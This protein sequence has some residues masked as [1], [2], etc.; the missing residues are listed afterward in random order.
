MS[1]LREIVSPIKADR[2]LMAVLSDQ[3]LEAISE[4][5]LR[6]KAY[7]RVDY[8]THVPA[9]YIC[10]PGDEPVLWMTLDTRRRVCYSR[11]PNEFVHPTSCSLA[12]SI[13]HNLATLGASLTMNSERAKDQRR[14]CKLQVY[15][16][17]SRIICITLCDTARGNVSDNLN[18]LEL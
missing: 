15:V 17:E 2:M 3:L 11:E 16:K 8:S 9:L 7:L 6:R 4:P 18:H 1:K 13:S 5:L 14:V 12:R 10:V